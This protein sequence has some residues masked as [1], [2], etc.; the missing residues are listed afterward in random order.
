MV[1]PVKLRTLDHWFSIKDST[2]DAPEG[3]CGGQGSGKGT[4]LGPV[5]TPT[6]PPAPKL[7]EPRSL[8]FREASFPGQDP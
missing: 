7:L 6:W 2:Q 8:G 4:E 3:R 1:W 5:T